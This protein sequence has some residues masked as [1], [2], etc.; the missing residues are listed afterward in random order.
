VTTDTAEIS[1]RARKVLVGLPLV[2]L[3]VGVASTQFV[4]WRLGYDPVL[5]QPVIAH[6]YWPWKAV[7]WW[8]A[9]WAPQADGTFAMLRLG[10]TGTACLGLLAWAKAIRKRPAKHSDIHG[11]ARL[12]TEA[13]IRASGLL[14][15]KGQPQIA[16]IIVGGWKHKNGALSY[17]THT[18]KTNVLSLG[19]PRSGKTQGV[20]VPT[21]LTWPGSVIVY[22]PKGELYAQTAGWR[23]KEANTIVMRL[24][25]ADLDNTI[26][27]NPFDRVRVGTDFAYRDV[28]NIIAHVADPG[29]KGPTDHWE[30]SAANFM[31]GIALFLL[32]RRRP[33][34]LNAILTAIDDSAN[35]ETLLQAMAACPQPQ[36]AS[37][38][39]G[40][41]ATEKRERGSIVSTA[42]RQLMIYRDP[43]MARNTASSAFAIDQ[44]MNADRP[45][46]LYIEARGEDELRL[47]PFVRLFLTIAIGQL[48]S[49][50]LLQVNGKE[51]P[52]HKHR[53]L[54]A[55]DEFASFGKMEPMEIALSKS[56]GF[57]IT[58]LLLAQD[59]QQVVAAYGEHE[60]ITGNCQVMAA[61]APN[62]A[63]SAD[64]LSKKTGQSTVVV[65]DVSESSQ[66]GGGKRSQTV[67]YRSTERP[68]LT[69]DEIYRLKAPERDTEGKITKAGELLVFSGGQHAILAT[70]SLA[71]LDPEFERRMAIPAPQTASAIPETPNA[72]PAAPGNAV[73]R[74]RRW[75]L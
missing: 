7:E 45:V 70:Q 39:R 42:R 4:A 53:L 48:I 74:P 5:G 71:F 72:P 40:M 16:G 54:L 66:Q 58:G 68:V 44:L 13:E 29:G 33:C 65:E 12:A 46:S 25:P 24:A 57:G 41:L 28:A 30:P 73:V 2:A 22:D 51:Q 17:L 50:P 59:Y 19:P 63:K 43:V 3:T 14:P 26:A 64:W 62:N 69:P 1:R 34:T 75:R 6:A 38:G 10:L 11:T 8:Q 31:V 55:V 35:P 36:A 20:L 52:P 49:K 9:P 32:D 56:S 23:R 27:W 18:G 37:V 21:L 60:N 61:Y 47:R 15:P 67:T